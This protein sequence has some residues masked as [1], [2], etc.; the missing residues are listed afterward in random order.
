NLTPPPGPVA[1]TMKP[2]DQVEPRTALTAGNTPGNSTNV[3]IISLP[4][5]Y[6]LMGT[7]HVPAGE[8]GILIASW[9]VTI[10]LNGFTIQGAP[11]SL[12]GIT[13]NGATYTNI[14][15]K[16]GSVEGCGGNGVDLSSS[17]TSLLTGLTTYI[18][19]GN[20]LV[21]AYGTLVQDCTAFGNGAA[22]F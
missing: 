18:N 11:G 15:V 8:N 16:N 10:D 3:F 2:L 20:G 21:A 14:I 19:G 13:T 4:G 22:G 6:Y 17:W 12:A 1:P 7:L 9:P 5:S